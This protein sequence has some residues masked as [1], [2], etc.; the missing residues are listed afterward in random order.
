M[1][2]G[3]SL[4]F[5]VNAPINALNYTLTGSYIHFMP[6]QDQAKICLHNI[7]V[8]PNFSIHCFK[9]IRAVITITQ[10]SIQIHRGIVGKKRHII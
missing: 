5:I 9:S 3:H 10:T 8:K 4:F 7:S 2:F 6:F 1:Q